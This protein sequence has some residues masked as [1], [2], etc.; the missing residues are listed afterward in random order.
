[1][2]NDVGTIEVQSVQSGS[3]ISVCA[4]APGSKETVLTVEV[5]EETGEE[6][7]ND[8]RDSGASAWKVLA[9]AVIVDGF[10]VGKTY[11]DAISDLFVGILCFP[12]LLES[13]SNEDF[14]GY[15]YSIRYSLTYHQDSPSH[16]VS[17]NN[18]T[19]DIMVS[20]VASLESSALEFPGSELLS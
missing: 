4:K 15:Y 18:T 8:G 10:L 7:V 3:D 13:R 12:I 6:R 19:R 11:S 1:M 9:A 5:R 14:M 16:S 2:I 20:K 17:S